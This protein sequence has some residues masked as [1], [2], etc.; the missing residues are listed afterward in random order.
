MPPNVV[1]TYTGIGHNHKIKLLNAKYTE[2]KL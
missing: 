1:K 2:N